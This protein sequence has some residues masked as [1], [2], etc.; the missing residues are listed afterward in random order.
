MAQ[1]SSP[2]PI[3]RRRVWFLRLRRGLN[4]AFSGFRRVT[5]QHRALSASGI[6]S[7]VWLTLIVFQTETG[8]ADERLRRIYFLEGLGPNLPAAG[9]TIEAFKQRLTNDGEGRFEIYADY[10]DLVRFPSK[11][12]RDRTATYLAGKY[13]EAPPDIVITLGR[14]A[15]SFMVEYRDLL[16]PHI[17]KILVSVPLPEAKKPTLLEDAF[18]VPGVYDYSKTLEL[19]Q[20]LHPRAQNLAVVGGASGYDQQWL[21]E[22][23]HQLAPSGGRYNVK[24]ITGLSYAETLR[25]VARL[26]KDTIILMSFFFADGTG[27]LF[28][29]SDV[30]EAVAKAAPAPVYSPIATFLGRG[31]VGGY[32]DSWEE[33]GAAAAETALDIL[34][35]KD[36]KDIVRFNMPAQTHRVDARQLRSWELTSSKLPPGTEIQYRQIGIWEQYHWHITAAALLLLVQA[37]IIAALFIERNRRQLAEADLRSRLMQVIHLNRS[38]TT[39]ALSASVAHELNQPLAAILSYAEAAQI[40]LKADPPNIERAQ[41]VLANLCQ[42]DHRAAAIINHVRQLL[43][44]GDDAAWQEFDFNDVVREALEIL[45]PEAI[46]RDLRISV[47]HV[48]APLLVRADPIHLQQVILNLAM[49]GM[50]AMQDCPPDG[51]NMSIQTALNGGSILEVSVA[52]TGPGVAPDKLHAIFETFYTTKQAGTGLG[53]SICRTIIETYGGKIWAENRSPNGSVFRFTLP[54]AKALVT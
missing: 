20:R 3:S 22:A 53:L 4:C 6:A 35:G 54:L 31:V 34:S 5:S 41:E 10:M 29:S 26:P 8:L 1:V 9:R 39:G 48:R 13:A 44:K 21:E 37:A 25:E 30:A 38:A 42:D 19:A 40:Y 16:A 36:V 43:R 51:R 11:A 7:A 17:P 2:V 14:A 23:R 12:H 32:M 46:K 47:S 49:N 52:D 18:W 27:Q 33:Q 50:D 15:A 24:Y 45:R 28:L